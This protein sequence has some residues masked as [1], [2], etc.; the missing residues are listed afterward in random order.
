MM[1][2]VIGYRSALL[3]F[4]LYYRGEIKKEKLISIIS[5]KIIKKKGGKNASDDPN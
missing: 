4:P 1:I 2:W 3:G 5:I